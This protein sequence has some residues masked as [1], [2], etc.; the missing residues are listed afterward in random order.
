MKFGKLFAYHLARGGM[1]SWPAVRYKQYKY[2][3][4]RR[5]T[6]TLKASFFETGTFKKSLRRDI[7]DINAFWQERQHALTSA[8]PAEVQAQASHMCAPRR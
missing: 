6:A 2:L 1:E 3:I 8:K 7:I 5:D 4:E